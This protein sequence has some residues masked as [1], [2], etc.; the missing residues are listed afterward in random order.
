MEHTENHCILA[1]N[2]LTFILQLPVN[3]SNKDFNTEIFGVPQPETTSPEKKKPPSW[4]LILLLITL[5]LGG[6]FVW[7]KLNASD[8][9]TIKESGS[10]GST[11]IESK[12]TPS[13][14]RNPRNKDSS[15][16]G[17]PAV[18]DQ[19]EKAQTET[20]EKA[21]KK[22]EKPPDNSEENTQ[23]ESIPKITI[24]LTADIF[25]DDIITLKASS[26]K[27]SDLSWR[28]DEDV[29]KEGYKVH[30][31]FIRPGKYT[32]T[33]SS[34]QKGTLDTREIL[35]SVGSNALNA[36][37]D[38]L[39]RAVR[40]NSDAAIEP[41][42]VELRTLFENNNTVVQYYARGGPMMRELKLNDFIDDFIVEADAGN[43]DYSGIKEITVNQK[44]GKIIK[45]EF[46]D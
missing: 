39:Y 2:I 23:E 5:A 21:Q 37:L 35:V 10:G 1:L 18:K 12:K 22:T 16:D 20:K 15:G 44:T 38:N 11:E 7:D 13:G 40:K 36:K 19:E 25:L 6:Y 3:M 26:D 41:A 30:H 43:K 29:I 27:L 28:I 46:Y 45:L 32:I 33:L 8:S 17:E 4:L 31:T 14:N 42:E 24:D 34:Q 9:E